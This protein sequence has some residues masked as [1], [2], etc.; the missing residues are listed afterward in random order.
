MKLVASIVIAMTALTAQAD[1]CKDFG[2]AAADVMEARQ[3]NVPMSTLMEITAK[4]LP[5]MKPV[6]IEAYKRPRYMTVEFR[7][8]AIGDFRNQ[9]ELACY[10]K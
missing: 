9:A 6:V 3:E 5:A 4:E 2:K 7:Q 10:S 1:Q 8:K